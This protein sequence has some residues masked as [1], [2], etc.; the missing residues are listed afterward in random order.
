MKKKK[1]NMFTVYHLYDG[2]KPYSLD[3]GYIGCTKNFRNRLCEHTREHRHDYLIRKDGEAITKEF[4]V[5]SINQHT[6]RVKNLQY[7]I[8]DSELTEDR[9]LKL[10]NIL[11]PFPRMGWNVHTGGTKKNKQRQVELTTPEG[12]KIIFESLGKLKDA[13]YRASN[14][15][16]VLSDKY[17]NHITF[18]GGCTIRYLPDCDNVEP[19]NLTKEEIKAVNKRV[20]QLKLPLDEP[21]DTVQDL[22]GD[23]LT[24]EER[25]MFT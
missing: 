18:D 9:A 2:D 14:A 3:D 16:R 5:R 21:L 20:Q 24:D 22:M 8:L 10:E 12:E 25:D 1:K 11:R 13:G 7:K 17:P 19:R 15:V 4:F 6:A 23:T